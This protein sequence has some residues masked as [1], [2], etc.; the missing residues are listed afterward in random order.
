MT[1]VDA[2]R[3]LR[4]DEVVLLERHPPFNVPI[5]LGQHVGRDVLHDLP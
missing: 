1:N 3:G 5:R 2:L 4:V